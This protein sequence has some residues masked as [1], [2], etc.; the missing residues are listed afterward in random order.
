VETPMPASRRSREE[1]RSLLESFEAESLSE[2]AFCVTHGMSLGYFRK[3]RALLARADR[4]SGFVRAQVAVAEPITVQI[5]DVQ[6]RCSTALPAAW[7]AELAAA[8]RG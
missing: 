5:Q 2:E 4:P 7:I 1:W 6:I 8:L 3:K